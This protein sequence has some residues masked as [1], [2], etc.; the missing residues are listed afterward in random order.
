MDFYLK[1]AMYKRNIRKPED[2]LWF[3]PI[4]QK[5]FNVCKIKYKETNK[6]KTIIKIKSH[7]M[8]EKENEK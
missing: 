1:G 4:W 3:L 2:G 6:D 7:I 5:M 8:N